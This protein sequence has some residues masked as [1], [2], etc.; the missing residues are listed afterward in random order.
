MRLRV[1]LL[2][3]TLRSIHSPITREMH[4]LFRAQTTF[5]PGMLYL[6]YST[7][8]Y[9]TLVVRVLMPLQQSH[10]STALVL[11]WRRQEARLA[12]CEARARQLSQSSCDM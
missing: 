12:S 4:G 8:L 9:S 10:R 1:W 7:V 5:I 2:D 11:A 3:R 6:Q